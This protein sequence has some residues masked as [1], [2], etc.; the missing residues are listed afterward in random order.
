MGLLVSVQRFAYVEI[1]YEKTEKKA[2]MGDDRSHLLL[3][4]SRGGYV[5]IIIRADIACQ[6]NVN[7][8]RK[9]EHTNEIVACLAQYTLNVISYFFFML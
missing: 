4:F 8:E 7:F 1:K 6:F 2:V 5:R 9:S 3:A